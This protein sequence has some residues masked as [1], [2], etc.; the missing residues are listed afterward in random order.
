MTN[1][2]KIYKYYGIYIK[3]IF[4]DISKLFFPLHCAVCDCRITHSDL[5]ICIACQ[6]DIP[7]TYYWKK[8]DNPVSL[9]FWGQVPI[10][11]ASAYFFYLPGTK[12]TN[13]IKRFK[14][15]RGWKYAELMGEWYGSDL[16]NYEHYND[17]DV[18][19][20]V[21]LHSHRLLSRGYNQSYW[22]SIG[23]SKQLNK[24]VNH[25]SVVRYR[26]NPS[27]T[28]IKSRTQRWDNV[29]NIFRIDDISKLSGKHILLVDDILTTGATI[30]SCALAIIDNVPD[31][32]ISIAVLAVAG[33]DHPTPPVRRCE[34]AQAN[35]ANRLGAK[36]HRQ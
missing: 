8:E 3:T 19:I 16:K 34:A 35:G 21:P 30:I 14:Y 36:P 28:T 2:Q 17:I 20:P 9:K 12:W 25:K 1:L 15:Y 33:N 31:C 6:Y 22:L 18:I 7:L 23:L 13:I 4:K 27:Q 5:D 29:E 26:N 32:K 11:S 24:P 10:K